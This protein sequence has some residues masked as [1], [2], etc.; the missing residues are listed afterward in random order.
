MVG[1][2]GHVVAVD[3]SE[4]FLST[5]RS[6]MAR[7]PVDHVS[8]LPHDIERAP[9]P[10][11]SADFVISR[12]LD[13]YVDDLEQ[14]VRREFECLQPGGRIIHFGTF[15]WACVALSPSNSVFD[16]VAHRI[17]A[18]YEQHGRQIDATRRIPAIVCKQ[19]ATLVRI[20]SASPVAQS[21]EPLWEWY[22]QFSC[23]ILPRV[24]AA[25]LLTAQAQDDYHA[26]WS[27][28][29]DLPGAFLSVPAQLSVVA[30][31]G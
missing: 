21:R 20:R 23:T 25:G 29:A 30:Q 10:F 11:V 26:L 12:W 18:F 9:L 19:N 27:D 16:R 17:A 8:V 28:Y 15:N 14:L 31:K 7:H 2:S 22:R 3:K 1:P 4:A 13:P 6:R 5:L 24:V